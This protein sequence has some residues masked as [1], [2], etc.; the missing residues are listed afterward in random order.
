MGFVSLVFCVCLSVSSLGS[1]YAADETA[2]QAKSVVAKVGSAV[3]SVEMVFSMSATYGGRTDKS[4]YKAD[5]TGTVIDPSGL[6][7]VA[8]SSTNPGEMIKSLMGS[9]G[10]ELN[11]KA[12]VSDVK[13]RLAD[14]REIPA[15]IVLRDR[16]LDLAF[17]RPSQKLE[18]PIP[19]V[20]LKQSAD[21]QML[22]QVIVVDRLGKIANRALAVNIKRVQA[23]VEKPRKAYVVN[24]ISDMDS[25]SFP[26]GMPVFTI[27]GKV[28]GIQV[29]RMAPISPSSLSGIGDITNYLLLIVLP[30]ADVAEVAQQVP[31]D[32]PKEPASTD[33]SGKTE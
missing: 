15:K 27:D 4:E 9:Y 14:G 13:L 3:V 18:S 6:T 24:T 23:V 29:L 10:S 26:V 7:V 20:D 30:A 12:D 5:V 2:A 16:D 19:Y 17:I 25:E 1:M 11:I 33:T 8:L 32:S 22:D 28:V 21:P 31:E